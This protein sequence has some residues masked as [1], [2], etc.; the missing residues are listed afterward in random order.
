MEANSFFWS[1]L[2]SR[3]KMSR[4]DLADSTTKPVPLVSVEWLETM[5]SPPRCTGSRNEL[6]LIGSYIS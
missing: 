6:K 2:Q 1:S 3:T 5:L 4:S